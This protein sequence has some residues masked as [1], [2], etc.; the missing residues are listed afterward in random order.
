MSKKIYSIIILL[1]LWQLLALII[2]KDVLMPQPIDVFQ[3]ILHLLVTSKF[4]QTILLTLVR[5]NLGFVI[6]LIS[7]ITLGLIGGL[8]PSFKEFMQPIIS[9]LQTIPQIS[10]IIILL[11]WFDQFLCILIIIFLMTFPIVYHNVISGIANI[12]ES[13]KDVICLYPQPLSYTIFHVYLPL[14]KPSIISA[15]LSILPLSLKI[16]VM[17]EVLIQ[18]RAGIGT[19]LYLA[20]MNIDMISVFAW[21]ICLVIMMTIEVS[22]VK[23]MLLTKQ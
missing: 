3:Q 11:V 12:D 8:N 15:I 4:Y 16:G 19:Q 2:A 14:I 21:T 17:A 23:K 13:L 10:F 5:A 7:G 6:A 18:T 20:R 9:F 1:A 22:L